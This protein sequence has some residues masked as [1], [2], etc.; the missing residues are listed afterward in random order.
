MKKAIL[1]V[2]MVI[3]MI[4]TTQ[5]QT[6]DNPNII[7][8]FDKDMNELEWYASKED[9]YSSRKIYGDNA[10]MEEYSLEIIEYFDFDPTTPTRVDG[11]VKIWEDDNYTIRLAITLKRT[12]LTV[13]KN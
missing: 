13:I 7:K 5:A 3:G 10:S 1:L 6:Y 9:N 2:A 11:V 4:S 8:S 12:H